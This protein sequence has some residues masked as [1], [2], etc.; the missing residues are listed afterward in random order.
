MAQDPLSTPEVG[1]LFALKGLIKL[2]QLDKTPNEHILSTYCSVFIIILQ[3]RH[4]SCC[5]WKQV[6]I[7][8]PEQCRRDCDER[9][10]AGDVASH[11]NNRDWESLQELITQAHQ[12]GPSQMNR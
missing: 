8:I 4:H 11:D 9:I 7:E 12:I 5:L 2:Q 6:V 3:R 1:K 10:V